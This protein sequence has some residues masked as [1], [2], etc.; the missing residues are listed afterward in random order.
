MYLQSLGLTITQMYQQRFQLMNEAF[1]GIKDILLLGR[2]E[3]FIKLL[4]NQE[5]NWLSVE[6]LVQH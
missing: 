2:D 5:K 3:N 4:E 6:V 1:G